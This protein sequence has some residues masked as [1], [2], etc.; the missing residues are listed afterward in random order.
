TGEQLDLDAGLPGQQYAWSTGAATQSISV[1]G[2]GTYEVE[3]TNSQGCSSKKIFEVS[4]VTTP[5]I[6]EISSE[7]PEVTISLEN[8]GD[9]LYSLDGSNYQTSNIFPSV[10]GGI[11]TAYVK[12]LAG[13]SV[14]TWEFAHLVLPQYI[15]PNNDGYHDY[16]EVKG[17][18]FFG[19][20]IIRIFDRYGKL[21]AYGR[22]ESFRW[23]GSVNSR[24]LPEED[25]WYS[26]DIEGFETIRG[27]FSLVR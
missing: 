7:G 26:I 1:S 12:N 27:H 16:F 6:R 9:F 18:A 20:S 3:I 21:L 4:G 25:Y 8:N 14:V 5:V 23:D 24:P 19:N 2:A 13:C 17:V 11:Y 10:G 15:T 22:G